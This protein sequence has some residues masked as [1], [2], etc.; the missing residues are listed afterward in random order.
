M[1]IEHLYAGDRDGYARISFRG[2]TIGLHRLVL[3]DKLGIDPDD[4]GDLVA[5]HTC[6]N[7]R[8][9]DPAHLEPGTTAD[10]Q[11]DMTERGRGRTGERNGLAVLSPEAVRDIRANYRKGSRTQGLRN[12]AEKY[13]CA[14]STVFAVLSGDTWMSTGDIS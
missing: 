8:C 7:T 4:L 2:A 14:I 9:I 1:C 5:R 10:N 13:R 12:F 11:R 3:A 6:D